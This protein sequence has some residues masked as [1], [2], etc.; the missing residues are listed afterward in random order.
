MDNLSDL[1]AGKHVN[2]PKEYKIIKDFIFK[3]YEESNVSIKI[4]DN[5]I[6]IFVNSS[7][8]AS[9]LRMDMPKIQEICDTQKR[10]V[11]YLNS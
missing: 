4:D 2:E 1:L 9:N 7:A 3:K 10:I 11:I 6:T 5:K 8:F